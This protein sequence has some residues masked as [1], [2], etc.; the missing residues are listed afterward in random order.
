MSI[1][2]TKKRSV[3]KG[4][5]WRIVAVIN[6]WVVLTLVISSSNIE[7]AVIMNISGFIIFY[8]FERIWSKIKYGRYI[9]ND[10]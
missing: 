10:K 2:E 8:I 5:T 1:I 7:K 4:I 3:F 9:K 6:S